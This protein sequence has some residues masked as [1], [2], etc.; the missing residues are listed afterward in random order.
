MEPKEQKRQVTHS[1][2]STLKTILVEYVTS[3]HYMYI[4]N[5]LEPDMQMNLASNM[6]K[7]LL[8]LTAKNWL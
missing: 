6:C 3:H 8:N 5:L 2:D 1:S 7:G 4:L